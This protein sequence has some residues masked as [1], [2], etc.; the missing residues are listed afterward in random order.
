MKDTWEMKD[1]ISDQLA[2][3]GSQMRIMGPELIVPIQS[4]QLKKLVE[5]WCKTEYQKR[6]DKQD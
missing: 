1:E 2:N 3:R 4:S 6:V 5:E